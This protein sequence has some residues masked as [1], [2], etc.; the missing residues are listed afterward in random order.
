MTTSSVLFVQVVLGLMERQSCCL[1]TPTILPLVG[2][3]HAATCLGIG[4]KWWSRR[5]SELQWGCHNSQGR[6]RYE[7]LATSKDSYIYTLQMLFPRGLNLDY[8]SSAPLWRLTMTKNHAVYEFIEGASLLTFGTIRC[9]CYLQY[10]SVIIIYA[11]CQ[12]I[13]TMFLYMKC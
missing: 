12:S 10:L 6:G 8:V 3:K 2:C 7:E 1:G 5:G 9:H 4:W 13:I 11:I